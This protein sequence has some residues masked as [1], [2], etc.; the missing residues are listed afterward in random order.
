MT[1]KNGLANY[2]RALARSSWA[3][4][5]CEETPLQARRI[6]GLLAAILQDGQATRDHAASIREWQ[7]A[8]IRELVAIRML[9]EKPKRRPR[10]P[11]ARRKK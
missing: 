2:G 5:E 4:E 7:S 3:G 10:K 11:K 6:I 1:N 8:I 9:L